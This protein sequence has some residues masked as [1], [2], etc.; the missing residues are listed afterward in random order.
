MPY[1]LKATLKKEERLTSKTKIKELFSK[2][3]SFG[4][5]PFK[6]LY[7]T[8]PVAYTLSVK[9]IFTVPKRAFKK[10]VDRNYIRRRMKEV[11]R[12]SKN[13]FY[14]GLEIQ[15]LSLCIIYVAKEKTEYSF[16]EKKLN[17]ALQKLVVELA[18][19]E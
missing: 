16:I 19:K 15:N 5:Y 11:Y 3:S 14:A 12:L 10:A 9:A 8:Q 6:F 13:D 2:S 4:L 17:L 18:G 1:S 7:I